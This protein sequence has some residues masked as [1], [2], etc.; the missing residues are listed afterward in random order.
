MAVSGTNPCHT[1]RCDEVYGQP[2]SNYH[3]VVAMVSAGDMA[4]KR[5]K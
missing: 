4:T 1:P 2:D 5:Q 3:D